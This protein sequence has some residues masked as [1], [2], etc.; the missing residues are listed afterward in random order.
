MRKLLPLLLTSLL[1]IACTTTK[2]LTQAEIKA[3]TTKQYE[4]DYDLVFSSS[5]SLLQSE[6]YLVTNADKSSGLIN[7][8]K[9]VQNENAD[10]EL[11]FLGVSNTS[12]NANIAIFISPI[13]NAY[14]E[15]KLTIYEGST[16]TSLG[17]WGSRNN[18]LSNKMVQKAEIYQTWFNNLRTEI[19][20]RKAILGL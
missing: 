16:R 18:T 14:T 15:I 1:I 4:A 5:V 6:G 8:S 11:F 12:S 2:Q 17:Y 10:L 20:R 3:M 13:N 9:E 19:E 7:A